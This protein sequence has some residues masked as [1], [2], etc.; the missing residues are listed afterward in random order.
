MLNIAICDDETQQ[1]SYTKQLV[2][3]YLSSYS[4]ET[5]LFASAEALRSAI[6]AGSYRPDIAILDI[7][8]GKDSGLDLAVELNALLPACKI[9]FLTGYADYISESYKT[10]HVWYVLKPL[11]EQYIGSALQRALDSPESAAE[12][13]GITAKSHGK[14]FFVPLEEILY[15][16]RVARKARI[17]CKNGIYPVSGAPASLLSA[18]IADYF[19]RCHQGYW[20]NLRQVRGL[21]KNE[22]VLTGDIRI[23]ISRS[24]L[25][26][27][28]RRFFERYK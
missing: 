22:F 10:A 18:D 28:R 15:L 7:D 16:D 23:P 2:E 21:E 11:A 6:R 13:L 27:S 3:R 19:V 8:L 5:E 14:A 12:A 17:V 24:Y 9:I 20:V 26:E 1:L 25:N 4:Y